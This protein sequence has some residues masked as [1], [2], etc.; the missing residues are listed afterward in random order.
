MIHSPSHSEQLRLLLPETIWLETEHFE[1]A[2]GLSSDP[3]DELQQWHRYLNILALLGLESWLIERLP[4]HAIHH[5]LDRVVERGSFPVGVIAPH[6]QVGDF[7][8]CILTTEHIL[9]ETVRIPRTLIDQSELSAQFYVLLEVLEEDAEMM[10]RGFLPHDELVA[11][12]NRTTA[13]T[14]TDEYYLL[15]LTALDP[16]INHLIFYAQ[17]AAPETAPAVETVPDT[18]ETRSL[19]EAIAHQVASVKTRLNRWID[20]VLEEGWQTIET[21]INPE[22]NLA[23]STRHLSPGV[24]GGKLVN[25]GLQLGIETV[26]L[27]I[28][29]RA[30]EEGKI[31]VGVQVLPTGGQA[32]LPPNL[33][34]KLLSR[35]A[36]V[37]Q[38][39]QSREL[40]N[41]IQLKPFKAK[42]G[43][44]FSIE[45]QLNDA[46]VREDFEID[47]E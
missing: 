31:G 43:A 8:L 47:N 36:E 32:F 28:T 42:P 41:Y 26:A 10:I 13:L 3:N 46:H 23:F 7:Q 30:E 19:G 16:E 17:H 5:H 40:D 33:T 29:V 39:V 37:R 20:G 6:L 45:I 24:K 2:K 34:L 9:D 35:T 1:Q 38:E 22:A 12:C 44:A 18:V 11:Q 25:L 27:L 4:N 15:P 14:H 21:L